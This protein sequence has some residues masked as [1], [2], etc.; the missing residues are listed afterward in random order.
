[1]FTFLKPGAVHNMIMKPNVPVMTGFVPGADSKN[2]QT[3]SNNSSLQ[4]DGRSSTQPS[5]SAPGGVLIHL[6]L[7]LS[8]IVFRTGLIEKLFQV[9]SKFIHSGF[10]VFVRRA[11][12]YLR[13]C[14][15]ID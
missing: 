7:V 1:M 13:S 9:V 5:S 6:K 4:S 2:Q 12:I 3:K 8:F 15:E 10:L 14:L 11:K